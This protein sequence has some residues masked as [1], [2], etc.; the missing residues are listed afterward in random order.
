M[1]KSEEERVKEILHN[2][3]G[4]RSRIAYLTGE[5]KAIQSE[6]TSAADLQSGRVWG[7]GPSGNYRELECTEKQTNKIIMLES[8]LRAVKREL[9]E[10]QKLTE[11]TERGINC[12]DKRQ[13]EVLEKK[14][15][16]GLSWKEVAGDLNITER[17][18]YRIYKRAVRQLTS[19]MVFRS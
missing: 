11:K 8:N 2:Y 1:A 9:T 5:I 10:T 16:G 17:T 18:C 13:R 12:L 14:F 6:I 4:N 3:A 19:T 7:G 15:I